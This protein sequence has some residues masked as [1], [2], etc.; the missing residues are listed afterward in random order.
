M[1][2]PWVVALLGYG[3]GSFAPGVQQPE[4][5]HYKAA[6]ILLKAH[7]EAYHV[8]DQEFRAEQNGGLTKCHNDDGTVVR[9]SLISKVEMIKGVTILITD[10]QMFHNCAAEIVF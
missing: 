7:A 2:E 10:P 6:H 1:N 4:E 8:Y 5:G 9:K 3:W